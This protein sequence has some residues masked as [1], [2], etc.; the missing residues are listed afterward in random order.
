MNQFA[1]APQLIANS[2][3]IAILPARIV[4]MSGLVDQLHFALLPIAIAPSTLK[5]MWHERN[6]R[7]P[8]QEWLRT[9]LIEIC[10]NL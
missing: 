10:K 8:A 7:H 4:Q 6:H 1:I 5:M 2:D 3:L 9:R